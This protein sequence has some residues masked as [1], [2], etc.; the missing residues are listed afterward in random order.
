MKLP[1]SVW[2]HEGILARKLG[3]D[4][5]TCPYKEGTYGWSQWMRGYNEDIIQCIDSLHT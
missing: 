4:A 2:Y 5:S 3:K 1:S